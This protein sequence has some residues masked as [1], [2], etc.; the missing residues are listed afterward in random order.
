MGNALKQI[1]MFCDLN[2]SMATATSYCVVVSLPS[3]HLPPADWLTPQEWQ[4]LQQA[5]EKRRCSFAWGRAM[6]RWL[7]SQLAAVPPAAIA[8]TLP[9]EQAPEL[10]IDQQRWQCS[11]SHSQQKLLV[12]V[13]STYHIAVDLEYCQT[14]RAFGLYPQLFPLLAPFCESSIQF[15]RRWTL[16]ET[17]AKYHEIPLTDLLTGA[18]Q[19]P[20]TDVN[21]VE[22]GDYL[23][24]IAPADQPCFW[25]EV[26]T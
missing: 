23:A 11:I 5:S 12:A 13:N 19:A 10:W 6:L 25:F 14:D 7:C 8:I 18:V 4:W 15:Y 16:L 9:S 22:I 26:S 2:V 1:K 17:L 21:Y 20:A 3:S 24:C